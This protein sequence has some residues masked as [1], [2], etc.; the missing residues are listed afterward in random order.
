MLDQQIIEEKY[1]EPNGNVTT[2]RYIKGRFLG[3][4]GFASVYEMTKIDTQQ[5]AAVK[6]IE[7]SSITKGRARQKL[8]N[9]IKIHR[10]LHHKHIVN[11]EHSFEDENNFYII[12][13]LCQ[14]ESMNY[15]LKRRKRLIELEVQC[16]L[17]QI[18][19]AIRHMHTQRVI[20]RDIKLGNIFLSNL[21]EVKM[22]DFGLAA[23]LEYDGERKRTICGTPNYIAPEILDCRNGHSYEVD[24]W[25]FG[26]LMYTMLVGRP[27][28]DSKDVKTTYSKIKV[29]SYSFPINIEI[30]QDAKNLI[31]RILVISP[32]ERPTIDEILEHP[33]FNRNK[34]PSLLPTCSLIVPLSE[35]Y[36][37]AFQKK[38]STPKGTLLIKNFEDDVQ[39]LPRSASHK[40]TEIKPEF[41][42]Q[43]PAAKLDPRD[44]SES[45]TAAA[46]GTATASVSSTFNIKRNAVSSSYVYAE[47]GPKVWV[48]SWVDYTHKYGLGYVLSNSGGGFYYNDMSKIICDLKTESFKYISKKADNNDETVVSQSFANV[49]DALQKK[50]SIIRHFLKHINVTDPIEAKDE[51]VVYVKKWLLTNHAIFFRLTNKVVQVYFKDYTEVLL[52]GNNKNLAYVDKNK[53]TSIMTLNECMDSGNR[54][55][56]KRLKYTKEILTGMLQ[57]AAE[58]NDN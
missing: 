48:K 27:P 41:L 1:T 14:N 54:E 23:R 40:N 45:Q 33:F 4:G 52:C 15:L 55:I 31:S 34:I 6:V 29:N 12:L 30:S 16:Y 25:S 51:G 11:F 46:T 38:P 47:G 56:I 36:V 24:I 20:H 28:F 49:P 22:G 58:N 37:K 13:E 17:L 53:K 26:V 7:K 43:S 18:L 9:E 42:L 8:M 19:S 5:V 35:S 10:S 44:R 32:T 21:M 39:K 57:N 3:K 2:K 50:V